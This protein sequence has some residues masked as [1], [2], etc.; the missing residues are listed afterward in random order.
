MKTSINEEYLLQI[1]EAEIT[2]NKL[3]LRSR[4]TKSVVRN[5]CL[6]RCVCIVP[7]GCAH[8]KSC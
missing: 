7:S 2:K 3:I 1:L 8:K 4:E 6:C 5:C